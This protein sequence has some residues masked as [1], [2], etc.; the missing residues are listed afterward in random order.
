M[1]KSHIVKLQ[2]KLNSPVQVGPGVDFVFPMSQEQE[3][4]ERVALQER[5]ETI[6]DKW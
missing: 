2:F 5:K 4:Q 1:N 3:E 6:F